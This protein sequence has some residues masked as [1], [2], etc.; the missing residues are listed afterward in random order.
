MLENFR[1]ATPLEFA[2]FFELNEFITGDVR[3]VAKILL[4][5][6]YDGES[7]ANLAFDFDTTGR[8]EDNAFRVAL[9]EA[10]VFRSPSR[11][12]SVWIAV[13]YYLR[14]IT[15][16][17]NPTIKVLS[18]LVNL[19]NSWSNIELYERPDCDAYF[20]ERKKKY[21]HT[22]SKFAAQAWGIE[23][24][25]GIFYASDDWSYGWDGSILPYD[26]WLKSRKEKQKQDAIS[27]AKRVLE[28]FF[29]LN[30]DLPDDLR[31]LSELMK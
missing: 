29:T 13:K 9:K 5:Q 25:Y 21:P 2:A 31:H 26:V 27:E 30:S 10:G 20:E 12:E 15:E 3:A 22:A 6:G 19:H 16:K 24:L 11:K 8:T 1:D 4:E 14:K 18:D 23:K 17:T 7:I 28:K